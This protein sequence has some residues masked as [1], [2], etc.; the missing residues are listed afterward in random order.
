ML[1]AEPQELRLLEVG[2]HLHL[3]DLRDDV[4]VEVGAQVLHRVVRHAHVPG[5][6]ELGAALHRAPGL[7]QGDLAQGQE[8]PV[9]RADD[10]VRERH[11]PVHEIEVQVLAGQVTERAFERGRDL[12]AAV[13]IAPQLGGDPELLARHVASREHALE[14]LADLRLVLIDPGAVEVAV[15]QVDGLLDGAADLPGRGLPGPQ[16]QGGHG[17]SVGERELFHRALRGWRHSNS[18]T[19]PKASS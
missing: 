16:P 9:R 18:S 3:V 12:R 11:R 8:V 5:Q 14:R 15:A 10:V 6:P 2:M 1:A 4:R 19:T 13:P 17:V 7:A